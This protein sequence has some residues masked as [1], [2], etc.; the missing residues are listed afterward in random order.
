MASDRY[1]IYP[2]I[3]DSF[4]A[5]NLDSVNVSS[6]VETLVR[7]AGGDVPTTA[8]AL[9]GAANSVSLQSRDVHEVL[10]NA[11]PTLSAGGLAVS[12][13]AKMQY[14]QKG[15]T[16][17]SHVTITSLGGFL[18]VTD[19]G[20]EQGSAE[21]ADINFVYRALSV[22]GNAPLTINTGA[23]ITGSPA[24]NSSFKLG[25]V[26]VK[27]STINVQGWRLRTGMSYVA[28]PHSGLIH[29]DEGT[30]DEEAYTIEIDTDDATLA[31]TLSLGESAQ[32][33]SGLTCYLR[34]I[35]YADATS[36]HVKVTA[37]SG[38]Y[39]VQSLG[40]SGSGDATLRITVTLNGRPTIA[41]N[42]TVT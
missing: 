40:G 25:P 34:R 16:G 21:G 29:A 3:F 17:S 39:V 30:I 15:Q 1:G 19:F 27:G 32:I 26:S 41:L 24:V 10:T 37:S 9:I 23:A 33:T 35:G 36:N 22:S 12:T 38:T 5:N 13:L 42:Q 11:G 28:K 6:D 31:S 8:S 4:T 18:Y 7:R 2:A 14:R 20:A